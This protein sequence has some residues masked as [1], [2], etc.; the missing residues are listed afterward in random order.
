M[1][2]LSLP[3]IASPMM[4]KGMSVILSAPVRGLVDFGQ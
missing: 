2:A 4:M 3:D 1:T